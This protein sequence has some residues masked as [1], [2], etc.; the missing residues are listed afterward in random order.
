[1]ICFAG[2]TR[3]ETGVLELN[4]TFLPRTASVMRNRGHVF[5]Q[6]HVQ[7]GGLKRSDGALPT[8]TGSLHSNLDIPHSKLGGLFGCLL[9]STLASKWS[10]LATSLEATGASAGPAKGVAFWVRDGHCCVIEGRVNV[11][12]AIG[13]I[14]ANTF[15]FV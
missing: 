15:L 8:G 3:H 1:M 12:D 13:D 10:A 14:A 4:A 6:L 11:G 9:S 7:A 5:N 2:R